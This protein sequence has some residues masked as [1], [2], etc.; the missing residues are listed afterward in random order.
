MV[1]LLN[2]PSP[3]P[4]P[5]QAVLSRSLPI[6]AGLAV[7]GYFV[8]ARWLLIPGLALL[9]YGA[10]RSFLHYDLVNDL[11]APAK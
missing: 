5:V 7:V 11:L 10:V 8:G 4:P 9:G 3:V 2:D 6:G 1:D